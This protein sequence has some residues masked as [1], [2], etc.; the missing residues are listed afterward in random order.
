MCCG[1][2]DGHDLSLEDGSLWDGSDDELDKSSDL[3]REWRRRHDQFHT[4]GYRD[5]LMAGKEACSQEGFNIGFK[6]SVL[7]GYRWGLVRGV[8]SAFA[9]L[10]EEVKEKLVEAHDKRKKLQGL[11]ESVHLLSTND[12][13]KSFYEDIQVKETS[14]PSEHVEVIQNNADLQEQTSDCSHL[15]NYLRQLGSL[16]PENSAIEMRLPE[17]K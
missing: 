2:C 17:P 1:D 12:A 6:E 3:D 9:Y 15:D 13:L 14:E 8:T 11:Y 4:L 16:I 10:P 5:G 7:A